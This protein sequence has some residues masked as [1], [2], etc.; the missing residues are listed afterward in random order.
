VGVGVTKGGVGVGC[1][2]LLLQPDNTAAASAQMETARS[3][4]WRMRKTCRAA[5]QRRVFSNASKG[6]LERGGG[7]LGLR[8]EAKRHA[9]LGLGV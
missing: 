9:A 7:L 8:R 3:M 4:A 6:T 1:G 5:S 2:E